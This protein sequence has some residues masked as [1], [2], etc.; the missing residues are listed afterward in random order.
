[1]TIESL[2]YRV[3]SKQYRIL[4]ITVFK[5]KNKTNSMGG[6]QREIQD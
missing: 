3:Y 5:K 1:M 2:D 4:T 6:R